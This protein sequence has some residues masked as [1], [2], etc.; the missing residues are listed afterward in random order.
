RH[1]QDDVVVEALEVGV[2]ANPD[3]DQ[4]IAGLGAAPA[5]RASAFE[6]QGLAVGDPLWHADVQRPAVRQ[7]D[8]LLGPRGRLQEV[9]L[10]AVAHVAP[11][12][13]ERAARLAAAA[14]RAEQVGEDV[15]EAEVVPCLRPALAA[16]ERASGRAA[17]AAPQLPAGVDLPTVVL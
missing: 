12:E 7:G 17:E 9:D 5:W 1:V 11:P 14:H 15:A 13:P 16:V 3:L 10:Q 6:P 2:R 8:A 4:R